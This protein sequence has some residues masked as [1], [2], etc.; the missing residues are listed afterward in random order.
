[1]DIARVAI[2]SGH[3]PMTVAAWPGDVFAA[4]HKALWE[5]A[6]PDEAMG[7][8]MIRELEELGIQ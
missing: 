3:D 2:A 4:M 7:R 8:D 1:M 5:R 6:N